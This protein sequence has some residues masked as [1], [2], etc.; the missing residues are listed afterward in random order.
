MARMATLF[1][2]IEEIDMLATHLAGSL[3][4]LA[5]PN[6]NAH[7]AARIVWHHVL[8]HG[9]STSCHLASL[10]TMLAEARIELE[11]GGI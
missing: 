7:D 4:P 11:L 10:A 8:T 5:D 3:D 2:T 6:N 9:E 1:L